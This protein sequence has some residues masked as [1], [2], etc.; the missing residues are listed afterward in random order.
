MKEC[1]VLL[2]RHSKYSVILSKIQRFCPLGRLPK[3][4]G[5]DKMLYIN[6]LCYM[7]FLCVLG[8]VV[9]QVRHKGADTPL[10]SIL[11]E[12]WLVYLYYNTKA[13]RNELS[14]VELYEGYE[15]KNQ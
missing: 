11:S 15:E 8:N 2:I 3:F 10:E 14:V 6:A 12:H 5:N 4:I 9:Y 13:K 7:I 1:A